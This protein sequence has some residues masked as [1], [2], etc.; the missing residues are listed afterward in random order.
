MGLWSTKNARLIR[1]IVSTVPTPATL[2]RYNQRE[3][4]MIPGVGPYSA[5]IPPIAGSL[6]HA[7][8]QTTRP[9]APSRRH[10]TRPR[11]L[12]LLSHPRWPS[13]HRCRPPPHRT[14]HHSCSGL[15]NLLTRCKHSGRKRLKG[16]V[17]FVRPCSNS[18]SEHVRTCSESCSGVRA[19]VGSP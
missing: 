7:V 17:L 1:P 8:F 15:T 6:F 19:H 16:G 11:H 13:R 12:S 5:L 18:D 3:H 14:H 9:S 4:S 2:P 10:Q